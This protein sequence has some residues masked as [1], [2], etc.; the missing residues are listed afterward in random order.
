MHQIAV[1]FTSLG[2]LVASFAETLAE[3]LGPCR[4]I[5]IAD[6]SLI[7]DVKL[8]GATDDNLRKRTFLHLESALLAGAE[9]IVIACSSVGEVA[10]AAQAAFPVPVI[11]IDEAMMDRALE[12]GPRIGVIASLATTVGPTVSFLREKAAE[13][14][15][16]PTILSAV[17]EGAYEALSAGD[18]GLH[19]EL[20]TRAAVAMSPD[21]DVILLAQGS[22]ARLEAPLRQRVPVP[23]LASPKPCAMAVRS[24]LERL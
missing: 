1:L 2:P 10:K 11:R 8:R 3:T 5:R 7:R 12:T 6:D 15:M 21:V 14:G 17:A 9:L 23:V 16:N 20:V 19:D 18:E 24:A 22:M 13:R 4:I